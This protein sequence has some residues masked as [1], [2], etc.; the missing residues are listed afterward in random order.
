MEIYAVQMDDKQFICIGAEC[1]CKRFI[2]I[3]AERTYK[4]FICIGV[5]PSITEKPSFW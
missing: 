4:R 5:E 3:G 2:C 1:T